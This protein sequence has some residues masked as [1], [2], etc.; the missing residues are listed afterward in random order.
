[1]A[2]LSFGRWLQ[3]SRRA[4]DLTQAELG[5]RIGYATVTIH[6][7]ETDQLRP[8]RELAQRLADELGIGPS[9]R[10]RF[11]CFARADTRAHPPVALP[12][13]P[14][15]AL[16][17]APAPLRHNLP[18]APTRFLG[19]EDDVCSGRALLAGDSRLLTLTGTGGIGKSRLGLAIAAALVDTF[20]DGV[21]F[22]DLAPLADSELV[23]TTV[24]RVLGL[25]DD[26]SQP[27]RTTLLW[28]L[29]ERHLL[30]VLDNCE[31]LVE[32]CARLIGEILQ[33]TANVRILA[34][35]RVALRIAGETKRPVGPLTLPPRGSIPALDQ[36]ACSVYGGV[37]T[38]R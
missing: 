10:E 12:R 31:H 25:G 33:A 21:W 15:R 18:V 28:V 13:L 1:M 23:V 9:E 19:R 14:Q 29:R 38:G 26:P 11:L 35:S 36:V 17:P 4:H 5:Q 20:A 24:A 7:I 34:T 30:L 3:R 37:S 2:E 8:S 27:L 22:V 6:K 16:A 32:A